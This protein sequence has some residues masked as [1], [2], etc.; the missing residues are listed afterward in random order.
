M[1]AWDL[2]PAE[3]QVWNR[4]LGRIRYHQKLNKMRVEYH[5][6]KKRL[7]KIGFSIPPS[8]MNLEIAIGWAEKAVSVPSARV[9]PDGFTS[10]VSSS[11]MDEINLFAQSDDY[12][13]KERFA[14]NA[15][16][17]QGCA[18]VFVTPGPGDPMLV[19]DP[20]VDNEPRITVRSALEATAEIDPRTGEVTA[21]LEI[22]DKDEYI[23]Y[24]PGYYLNIVR[25]DVDGK[26]Y[27]NR[28]RSGADGIVPCSIY[29]WKPTLQNPYGTSR[30][31]RPL[32]GLVDTGVRTMLRQE[33]TAEHFSAPQRALLGADESHFVDSEGNKISPL[34]ALVGGVWGLPDV[35]DE[36]ED[37]TRRPELVQLAQASMAPH[38]EMMRSI[39][40]MVSSET[41]IPLGYLGVVQDNPSSADAILASESDM[42]AMIEAELP[43]I[44]AARVDLARKILAVKYRASDTGAIY[45]DLRSLRAYFADPGT[46]TRAARADAALKFTTAFPQADPEVA[47]EMYGLTREQIA[48]NLAY[49]RKIS[50]SSAVDALLASRESA[51]PAD[52]TT[53]ESGGADELKKKF[54]ALG[55]AI[56]AGVDPH[57]AAAQL[58]LSGLQFVDGRPITLKYSDEAK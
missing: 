1:E 2:L 43:N 44:G 8:M 32:M 53:V 13:R 14:I 50:A 20:S 23:L 25:S 12:I 7:D 51:Q 24:L 3:V 21:A 41:T 16:L 11:L 29:S 33:T 49:A 40:S 28:F 48:R 58:G 27:S 4:L 37:K 9:R 39:A 18:F 38:S 45:R 52:D 35:Y 30:I 36:E 47:M 57:N 6:S 34:R 17:Q 19:D 56:R 26:F 54:D 22:T 31:T 5:D 15:A 42:V 55:V 46:P 10:T